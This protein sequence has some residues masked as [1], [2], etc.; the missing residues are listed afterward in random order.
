MPPGGRREG[1]GRPKIGRAT[2]KAT[3][4]K[5]DR[6]L[7]NEYAYS[8]GIPVNELIHIVFR[9]EAF[10]EYFEKINK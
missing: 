8:L 4:Y 1:A 2:T 5:E 6:K 10:E 3:I 7:I 9:H